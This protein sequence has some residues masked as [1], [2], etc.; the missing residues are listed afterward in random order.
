M[1]NTLGID[2]LWVIATCA[3]CA[4]ACALPGVFLV[5]S[6]SSLLADGIS[7]SA[8]AGVGVVFLI[9]Q[10]RAPLAMV[11]GA[12]IAGILT[13]WLSSAI[14]RASVIK[15]DAAL[16][17]V[18]TTLFAIGVII[19]TVAAREVDL[20]PGCILYGVP[21]FIAFDTINIAGLD[22]PRAFVWL[23]GL[24]LLNTTLCCTF[25]KELRLAIFDPLLAHSLGFHPSRIHYGLLV[26]ITITVVLS[27]EA[28]GSILVVTMLVAPAAAAHLWSDRLFAVVIIA[29]LLGVV[30][31]LG[32]YAGALALNSSL[33]GV[34][35][36]VAGV[37]FILAALLAPQRGLVPTLISRAELRYR[38]VR[39]DILGLLFRWHEMAA[40]LPT[41]KSSPTQRAATLLT[42]RQI[43]QA[44]TP[45]WV[46]L[47]AL[48]SLRARGD[49]ISSSGGGL[50]LSERGLVEARAVV[51]S[52]R[53][54]EAYLAKHLSLPADHLHAPS[55]RAEHFIGRALAREIAEDVE[56]K[57]DPHG[58]VIP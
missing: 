35:S 36:V 48:R 32:G 14:S 58:K 13:A 39:D 10:T 53:L 28:L 16:G 15:S 21:E 5:L 51:R 24:L 20:D 19:V 25:W 34:M 30:S 41:E 6:R 26:C 18:F 43:G 11:A 52:H 45:W 22:V 4:A 27:F 38:I 31:A 42:A 46:A 56:S 37:L 55:E 49:I 7:H 47:L 40:Q 23:S 57:K 33:A 12:L 1:V 2:E 54:W 8:L 17:M 3:V 50:R 44:I 29:V 9:T